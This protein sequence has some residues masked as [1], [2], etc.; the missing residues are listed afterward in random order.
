MY[1][2][3]TENIQRELIE[4]IHRKCNE[5]VPVQAYHAGMSTDNLKAIHRF[6]KQREPEVKIIVATFAFGTGLDVQ[7]VRLVVH[8]GGSSGLLGY[9]QEAGRA[10]RDGKSVRCTI[11][12]NKTYADEHTATNLSSKVPSSFSTECYMDEQ[13]K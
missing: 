8:F 11:I 13:K 7:D 10:V 4:L 12:Y 3:E 6:R 5:S 9:A 1:R 2:H